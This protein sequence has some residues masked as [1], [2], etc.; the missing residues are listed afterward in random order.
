M[1]NAA[2]LLHCL[3]FFQLSDFHDS[4][5]NVFQ[6]VMLSSLSNYTSR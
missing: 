4:D 1:N 6:N 3:R 5:V 2:E